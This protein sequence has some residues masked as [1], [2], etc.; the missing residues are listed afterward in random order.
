MDRNIITVI[1]QDRTGD[2]PNEYVV[3]STRC[4]DMM[5]NGSSD[6]YCTQNHVN[7]ILL[8]LCNPEQKLL[9]E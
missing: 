9:T 5:D 2:V 6:L 4:W 3:S 8:V 1:S 7:G